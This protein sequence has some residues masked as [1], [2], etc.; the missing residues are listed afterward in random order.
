[1]NRTT[2]HK[3][4]IAEENLSKED[5][6]LSLLFNDIFCSYEKP[7]FKFASSLCKDEHVAHDLLH[8]VFMK[9]WEIR[10]QLHEIKSI[11]SFLFTMTRNKVMDYL[12]KTAS[13]A[14]LR[15]AIWESMQ[16]I[17]QSHESDLE[18]KEYRAILRRAVDQLP[19]QRKAVYLLRDAGFNYQEIA[20]EMHISK[21]TVKNQVSAALKSLRKS[22]SKF[23][24][25]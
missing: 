19:A 18:E 10:H 8:D 2:A 6:A 16:A 12:R 23:L 11:E 9:L 17:V 20:A 7:L 15:A 21:H 1:M 13:D 24:S 3:D 4:K 22:L 25:F 5:E 14:R